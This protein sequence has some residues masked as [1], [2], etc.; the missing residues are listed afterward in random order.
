MYNELRY[1]DA[2]L[3]WIGCGMLL[4]LVVAT[5]LSISDSR[6]ILGINPWIKPM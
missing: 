5:L 6:L 1:R 3:F 2:A 4:T